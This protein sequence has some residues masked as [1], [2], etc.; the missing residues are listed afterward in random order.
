MCDEGTCVVYEDADEC[1]YSYIG[2]E[3]QCTEKICFSSIFDWELIYVL[4]F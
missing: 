2:C 3:E 4:D 1:E